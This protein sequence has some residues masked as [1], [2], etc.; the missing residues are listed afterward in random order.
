MS[1]PGGLYSSPN[2]RA[3]Q[4]RESKLGGLERGPALVSRAG[5]EAGK[6]CWIPLG[7]CFWVLGQL[8]WR[9]LQG[10]PGPRQWGWDGHHGGPLSPETRSLSTQPFPTSNFKA[11]GG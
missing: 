5:E 7:A 8:G 10:H 2:N 6:G 1:L 9:M 4:S 3:A 11:A